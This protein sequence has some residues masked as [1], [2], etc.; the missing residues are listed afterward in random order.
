MDK[1]WFTEQL[2]H[3]GFSVRSYGKAIGIDAAIMSRMFSGLRKMTI[4]DAVTFATRLNIPF[5]EV[6]RRAGVDIPAAVLGGGVGPSSISTAAKAPAALASTGAELKVVGVLKTADTIRVTPLPAKAA[7]KLPPHP[8]AIRYPTCGMRAVVGPSL[9]YYYIVTN[10]VEPRAVGRIAVICKNTPSD[11][12]R[13]RGA[14]SLL[15]KSVSMMEVEQGAVVVGRLVH[16]EGSEEEGGGDR[17]DVEPLCGGG[18]KLN[19][20]MVKWAAPVTLMTQK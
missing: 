14:G 15:G 16:H 19:N 11:Y 7:P 18:D 6:V 3:R 5:S 4:S 8:T 20:V 10:C 1:R 13:R 9:V 17:W 12:H 2:K